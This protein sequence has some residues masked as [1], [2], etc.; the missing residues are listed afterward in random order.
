LR[1][2]VRIGV[3]LGDC[4]VEPEDGEFAKF[5][6]YCSRRRKVEVVILNEGS[7]LSRASVAALDYEEDVAGALAG[8]AVEH[9]P[10]DSHYAGAEAGRG[11]GYGGFS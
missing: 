3:G 5:E 6:L 4:E 9:R 10:D 1:R 7:I 11:R 8:G 2:E